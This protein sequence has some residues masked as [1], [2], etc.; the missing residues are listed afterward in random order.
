[1]DKATV[2][3]RSSN[4]ADSASAIA[5]SK[6]KSKAPLCGKGTSMSRT[7]KQAQVDGA[8]NFLLTGGPGGGPL[9]RDQFLFELT[10][11]FS[12]P[13]PST[14]PNPGPSLSQSAIDFGSC[15]LLAIKQGVSPS[16]ATAPYLY[17]DQFGTVRAVGVLDFFYGG[18]SIVG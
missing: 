3:V 5:F 1:V 4:E 13:D 12:W 8:L 18:A 9:T 11:G 17:R 2:A 14:N 7:Y 6:F 10:H 15:L 16:L